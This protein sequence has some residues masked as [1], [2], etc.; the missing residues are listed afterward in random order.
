VSTSEVRFRTF[1]AARGSVGG[2]EGEGTFVKS[3]T[4][5]TLEARSERPRVTLDCEVQ[6]ILLVGILR[7][8][9]GQRRAVEQVREI[10]PELSTEE[11]DRCMQAL[12]VEGLPEWLKPG[13]WTPAMD[14]ILF[15]GTRESLA[16]EKKAVNKILKL[17]P[18]L[19]LEVVWARLRHLRA[20]KG[21][22]GNRGIPYEWTLEMD[23]LLVE[24]CRANDLNAAVSDVKR[25]TGYPRDAV[26]RHAYKLGIA[27][28]ATV[29]TR[30]WTDAELRFL[31]ESVQHL[32]VKTIARELRRTEK[33][34]WRKVAELGLSAK[35]AEGFTITE[36][37]KRLH[38]W[39]ARIKFLIGQG[40]IKV[41]RNGRITE[42]SLRSFLREHRHELNWDLFDSET[43]E[44]LEEL[45]I[46]VP[47]ETTTAQGH[48]G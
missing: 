45:G 11:I 34:I 13:F 32:A 43:C 16:A 21:P 38:V 23:A 33:A 25:M 36:V 20:L 6:K 14:Q 2:S 3:A 8:W 35:C 42:R 12:A 40:R 19:R 15:A 17:K 39:H 46:E 5:K 1:A 22:K 4:N 30:P 26:L 47:V 41:G 27:K 18:E 31:V 9:E 48:A 10:R 37:M 29:T 24:R 44:W 7:G 28:P